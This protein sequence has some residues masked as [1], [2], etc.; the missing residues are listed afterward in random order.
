MPLVVPSRV[1]G[2][3]IEADALHAR[4][5]A[6]RLAYLIAHIVGPSRA[7]GALRARL[8]NEQGL[9]VA[10]L[11]FD[12]HVGE[13][14][15]FMVTERDGRAAIIQLVVRTG[16]QPQPIREVRTAAEVPDTS[17]QAA[18]RRLKLRHAAPLRAPHLL[19]RRS[20][21]A[22]MDKSPCLGRNAE[23]ANYHS[24]RSGFAITYRT[25]GIGSF[26]RGGG[27]IPR[28]LG[29]VTSFSFF[30]FCRCR[31]LIDICLVGS[32]KRMAAS[33]YRAPRPGPD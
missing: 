6:P 12:K 22:S 32:W 2:Y 33:G 11:G 7:R 10:R 27:I 5:T 18:C 3:W 19:R 9:R 23:T 24:F 4:A 1:G 17:R 8:R 30:A 29:V 15:I 20:R 14:A 31:H 16:V 13:R 21:E 28:T 25:R 26:R